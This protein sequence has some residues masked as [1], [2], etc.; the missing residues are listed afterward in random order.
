[1]DGERVASAPSEPA[2]L[3]LPPRDDGD[4]GDRVLTAALTLAHRD[5]R[6][7]RLV[8]EH[9]S[10]LHRDALAGVRR[11]A[12]EEV[13]EL[14]RGPCSRGSVGLLWGLA[15]DPRDE[16]STLAHQWLASADPA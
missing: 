10:R 3:P 1:V 11:M 12:V 8:V 16:V 5:R 14:T 4:W 9:L 15:T 2:P 6:F 13:A 7:S